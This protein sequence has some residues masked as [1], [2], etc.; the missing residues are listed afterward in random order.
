MDVVL[1]ESQE[2]QGIAATHPGDWQMNGTTKKLILKIPLS[3]PVGKRIYDEM[4]DDKNFMQ[5][6]I[7]DSYITGRD[8][9]SGYDTNEYSDC[10]DF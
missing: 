5:E 7:E 10:F 6:F 9:F 2:C 4:V 1:A 8:R 3:H